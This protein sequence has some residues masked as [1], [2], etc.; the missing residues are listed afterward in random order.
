MNWAITDVVT[1]VV[2]VVVVVIVVSSDAFAVWSRS[3]SPKTVGSME[4]P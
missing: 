3:S 4:V 1:D 2:V